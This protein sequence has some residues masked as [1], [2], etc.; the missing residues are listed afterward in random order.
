LDL[1]P[2]DQ[3]TGREHQPAEEI[4]NKFCESGGGAEPRGIG[5]RCLRAGI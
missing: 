1:G 3:I 5:A 4:I 2:K